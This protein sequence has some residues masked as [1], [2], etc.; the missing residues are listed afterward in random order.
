VSVVSDINADKYQSAG[1]H[2][3]IRRQTSEGGIPEGKRVQA[4]LV[5][6]FYRSCASHRTMGSASRAGWFRGEL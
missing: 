5:P 4:P 2:Q 6:G 3:T 1:R